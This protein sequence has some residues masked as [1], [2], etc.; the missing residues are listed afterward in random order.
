MDFGLGAPQR[1]LRYIVELE[2]AT[3]TEESVTSL[4]ELRLLVISCPVVDF[5]RSSLDFYKLSAQ[6]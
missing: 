4:I 2:K 6:D 3:R 1:E 5:A